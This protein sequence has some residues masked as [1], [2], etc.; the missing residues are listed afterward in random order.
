MNFRHEGS[1]NS[2]AVPMELGYTDEVEEA[3]DELNAVNS[4]SGYQ[5]R[6]R[7]DP[8]KMQELRKQG[9]CFKCERTGHLARDCQR[10]NA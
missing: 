1:S 3:H 4:S 6:K 2:T 5:G 7:M 9:K 8:G 10:K